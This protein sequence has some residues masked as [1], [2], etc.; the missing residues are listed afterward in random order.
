MEAA[1]AARTTE[2]TRPD[3]ALRPHPRRALPRAGLDGRAARRR[4][5]AGRSRCCGRRSSGALTCRWRCSGWLLLTGGGR[6]RARL[7]LS[8]LDELPTLL[9]R[10]L[11]AA[12]VVATVIALRHEQDAVT[13]FLVNA[14][15]RHRP[16]RRGPGR[17]PT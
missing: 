17:A 15:D 14:V 7:H 4:R 5:P 11:T 10:L 13:T 12:A 2:A 6:Y 3:V 1:P 9:G 16:G 8:V